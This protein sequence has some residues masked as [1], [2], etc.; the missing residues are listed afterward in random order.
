MANFMDV[1][2]T[3]VADL[4]P[5]ALLPEGTYVWR[6]SKVHKETTTASG[7]WFIIEI[8][9]Q[10]TSAYADADDVDP[11]EL[12]AFGN[13]AMGSNSIR[14]MFPTGADQ[15]NERNRSSDQLKRFLTNTLGVETSGEETLK[16]LLG[17]MVGAE[18]IAQA[19][20]RHVVERDTT[21][22]DVKNYMPLP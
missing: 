18:F 17:Q 19:I 12:E 1:L 20:H 11:A 21:Y 3:K 2:N 13:L 5:P 16:E 15:E 6:V 4:T 9:V 8:P 22:I 7:E 14:F 10:P